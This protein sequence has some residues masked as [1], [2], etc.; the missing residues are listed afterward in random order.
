MVV[1]SA[2]T[3]YNKEI[4]IRRRI[5]SMYSPPLLPRNPAYYL[6]FVLAFSSYQINIEFN[7]ESFFVPFLNAF[8]HCF[9]RSLGLNY[10]LA[11]S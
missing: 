6:F 5:S 11:L 1:A 10:D 7:L 8:T 3:P 2:T 4:A 9:Y